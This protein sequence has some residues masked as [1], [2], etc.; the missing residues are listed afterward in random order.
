MSP[1]EMKQW[2]ED[3]K[4]ILARTNAGF[5]VF[6]DMRTLKPLSDKTKAYMEEG[7]KLYKAAGMVRS[8]V[9]LDSHITTL[10]FKQIAKETGIY[11]WERYVNASSHSD[12]EA[13]GL[14]W[15]NKGID[16]D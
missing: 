15:I 12:W 2:A 5:G 13:I 6:I 16:P 1:E 9:I 3:S 8:V 10:Q 11:E 4:S 14:A 7:Q